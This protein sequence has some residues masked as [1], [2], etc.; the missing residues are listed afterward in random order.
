MTYKGTKHEGAIN[1]WFERFEAMVKMNSDFSAATAATAEI[2]SLYYSRSDEQT[3][4]KA[5]L[6]WGKIRFYS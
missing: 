6:L 2:N 1:D 5:C 3:V 4:E